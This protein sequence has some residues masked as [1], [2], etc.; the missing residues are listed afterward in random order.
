MQ[1]FKHGGV[2]ALN[3]GG[4]VAAVFSNAYDATLFGL[5]VQAQLYCHPWSAALLEREECEPLV[6]SAHDVSLGHA[7]DAKGGSCCRVRLRAR[8]RFGHGVALLTF[9]VALAPTE[10]RDECLKRK[11]T[12]MSCAQ[13]QQGV[14]ARGQ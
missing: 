11:R 9:P 14:I 4:R 6:V 1:L 8:K 2:L 5:A 3:G 13:V 10:P 7:P 12:S